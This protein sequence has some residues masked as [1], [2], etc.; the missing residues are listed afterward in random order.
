MFSKILWILVVS[1]AS[2]CANTYMDFIQDDKIFVSSSLFALS[3]VSIL[4]LYISSEQL[5][6]V[7]KKHKLIM[8]KEKDIEKKQQL[9]LELMSSKIETSTK[10]M[11][12][13]RNAFEK[14][15]FENMTPSFFKEKIE[16]FKE[17]E[18]LLLDATHELLDFLKIKSGTLELK[19]ESYKIDNLLNATYAAV[20]TKLK[21][22]KIELIYNVSSNVHPYLKGDSR[23]M[24]QLLSTVI[25][26][27]VSTTYAENI[28]LT[29]RMSATKEPKIIFDIHNSKKIM[30]KEEIEG[31]FEKYTLKE[32]YKSPEKLYMYVAYKLI[33]QMGG[34]F[35]IVSHKNEGTHYQMEIPYHPD[36]TKTSV[37]VPSI[38]KNKRVLLSVAHDT[39]NSILQQTLSQMEISVDYYDMQNDIPNINQ[40]DIL[41]FDKFLLNGHLIKRLESSKE[42]HKPQVLILRN[43][44]DDNTGV[45]I[46]KER[47]TI[48][49]KPLLTTQLTDAIKNMFDKKKVFLHDTE[50]RVDTSV[51]TVLKETKNITRD[52]FKSFAH[53]HIL[54]VEDNIMN[55]KI[56]KGVFS[57]SGMTI[58]LANNGQEAC[59]LVE[60]STEFDLIFM[61][62]NMPV[63]DGYEASKRIRVSR[64][65]KMLPIIAIDSIGFTKSTQDISAINAFLHKPFKIGQLYTAL[66]AYTSQEN[67]TVKNIANKLK[68]YEVKKKILDIHKG[69]S[70]ANTA[71]FYKEVLKET[72]TT[73]KGSDDVL[74]SYIMGMQYKE[75]KSFILDT[76]GLSEI[77]GA[78][79]LGR[80]LTE[81]IQTFD[82]K[83]EN[84]LQDYIPYYKKE[85]K[86][87]EKEI[88]EYLKT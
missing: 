51:P 53:L 67:T 12:A 66:S 10:G 83:Q 43:S 76:I 23:R 54:I 63:M 6:E 75:L 13:H 27:A 26:D 87:L 74:T 71:I 29:I 7:N 21:E 85:L 32:E 56:L 60:K 59:D 33:L 86:L 40:Y 45:R 17:T 2:L 50:H 78:M 19:N 15:N 80:V 31:L 3:F 70:H 28:Q 82:Y 4:F 52:R 65:M 69:I 35:K 39:L 16:K 8:K 37:M 46:E 25:Q 68:K 9:I 1:P 11:V 81:M 30:L 34:E 20:Y 18:E 41:I 14:N 88:M 36:V 47:V 44:Y 57:D 22:H 79:G 73:L 72:Y 58:T 55:Q 48:L 84:K 5:K 61:D 77:I 24:E 49:N 62:I 64:S 42:Q 38:G